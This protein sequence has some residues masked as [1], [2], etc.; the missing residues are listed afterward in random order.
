MADFASIKEVAS[1][2]ESD[3]TSQQQEDHTQGEQHFA[4]ESLDRSLELGDHQADIN[5]LDE[6][7]DGDDWPTQL[8]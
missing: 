5:L 4:N 8:W 7:V 1:E 3:Q 2:S 6:V